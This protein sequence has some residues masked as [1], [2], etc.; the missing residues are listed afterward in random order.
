[1]S[2]AAGTREVDIFRFVLDRGEGTNPTVDEDWDPSPLH[3]ALCGGRFD[4]VKI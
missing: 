4:V 2:L 3:P 1:L